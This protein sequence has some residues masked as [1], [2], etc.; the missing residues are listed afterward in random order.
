MSKVGVKHIIAASASF[1]LAAFVAAPASADE[2]I[3][4]DSLQVLQRADSLTPRESE[5]VLDNNS[6]LAEV[7]GES[8]SVLDAEGQVDVPL[9][10][11]EP[12]VIS[13]SGRSQIEISRPGDAISTEIAPGVLAAQSG[14]SSTSVTALKDDG[15]VQMATILESEQAPSVYSYDF[16]LP[17]GATIG[18]FHGGVI[19]RDSDG[20]L[21]GGFPEAWAKDANGKSVRTWYEIQGTSVR[22]VIDHKGNQNIKYPIVADPAYARGMIHKVLQE[23]WDTKKGG[24]D[25]RFE[26]TAWAR[27]VQPFAPG[28]VYSEGLKD[29]R[30]HHPRSMAKATMA[31]QWHCHVTGLP[32]TYNIGLESWR[33]SMPDWSKR[34]LPSI[35][36]ANPAKACNW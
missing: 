28:T 18:D 26:V 13:D 29:L 9:D 15:S 5:L 34:I 10:T 12:I 23:K 14:D 17:T 27:W 31:Q 21:L 35:I 8:L 4:T 7:D 2:A 19:I 30:E 32:G 3:S 24:W 1:A 11:A 22:Q 20:N 25:I 36:R 16:S 6:T 33:K